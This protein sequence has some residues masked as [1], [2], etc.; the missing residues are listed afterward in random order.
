L[1]RSYDWL[2][3]PGGL[4]VRLRSLRAASGLT[5]EE[6]ASRL[7]WQRLRVVKIE[8]GRQIP[9]EQDITAWAEACGQPG[10]AQELLTLLTQGRVI[11]SQWRHELRHGQAAQQAGWADLIRNA[12]VVRNYELV[13]IPGLLQTP[14]YAR[15]R[16][17]EAVRNYGAD[18]AGVD[19]A[20]A[21]KMQRQS[22][23]YE[24]GREF[25]FV[26][27]EAA[28]RIGA[29][30]RDAMIGQLDRL[31]TL[32]SLP[33]ITLG[34]I[35]FGV[36]LPALPQNPFIIL[37]DVVSVETHGSEITVT[38]EEAET[39]MRLADVMS[40][41]AATGD[42]ARDVIRAALEWWRGLPSGR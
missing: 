36:T 22:V 2:T 34:V 11:H 16:A 5:G 19:A 17:L 20:V 23:L 15:H 37:G 12:T 24:A 32:S 35:P 10:E 30:P 13:C 33:G 14:D 8:N 29:C 25:E 4:S 28:L 18:P 6:L 38:G 21:A 31:A 42:Q 9:S 39:Y 27:V 7:G 1:P 41:E 3:Q 40:A 26:L